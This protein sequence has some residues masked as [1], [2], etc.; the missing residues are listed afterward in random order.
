MHI[1]S[2]YY[3]LGQVSQLPAQASWGKA[4]A[5]EVLSCTGVAKLQAACCMGHVLL[6]QAPLNISACVCVC[7]FRIFV[8]LPIISYISAP[9]HLRLWISVVVT[10]VC[11]VLTQTAMQTNHSTEILGVSTYKLN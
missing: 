3:G 8:Y 6:H 5:C 2:C 11:G 10:V 4:S 7:V 9:M 1:E